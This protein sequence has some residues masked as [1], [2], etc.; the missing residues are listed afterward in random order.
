MFNHLFNRYCNDCTCICWD[1][2]KKFPGYGDFKIAENI[3]HLVN[4][5]GMIWC[6]FDYFILNIINFKKINLSLLCPKAG[7]VLFSRTT[8]NKHSKAM[9]VNVCA[10]VGCLDLQ[11]TA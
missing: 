5:Q 8:G 2:E 10:L 4:N 11:Y 9:F 6:E 7:N 1:L 3:L